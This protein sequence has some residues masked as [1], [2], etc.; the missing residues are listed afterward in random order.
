MNR[1]ALGAA[2]LLT[3]LSARAQE[4]AIDATSAARDAGAADLEPTFSDAEPAG[5]DFE[6]L[7]KIDEEIAKFGSSLTDEVVSSTKT[8]QRAAQVPA[9][10]SVVTA[11]EIQAR[12]YTSLAEVL[13]T[14]PGFYDVFDLV[15]HNIGVRGVNGGARASGNIIKLMIDGQ[16]VDYRP[17]TGNFFGEELIPLPLIDH[18]EII[19]GPASA[20]YGANAFLGV[21]NLIT[22]TGQAAAGVRVFG[23]GTLIRTNPGGGGGAMA[24]ISSEM[25]DVLVGTQAAYLNRSGLELPKSSPVL[26]QSG[27]PTATRSENDIARPKTL[28]AKATA[29]LKLVELS[30][31]ASVQNLDSGGEFLDTGP[32]THGTRVSLVNQNYRLSL[33]AQPLEA[34]TVRASAHYLSASPAGQERFDIGERGYA[35]LR[36]AGVDGFGA[37]GEVQVRAAKFLTVTIGADFVDEMYLLQTWDHLTTENLYAADGVTV[38][39]GVGTIVP[40]EAH[41]ARQTFTNVGG[42]VQGLINW[43]DDFSTVLG[44]RLDYHSLYQLNPSFRLGVVYAPA[45]RPLSLKLLYGSSFKAPSAEQLYTQPMKF[46][47]VQGNPNLTSQTAHTVELAAGFGFAS[48][49]G[50]LTVNAFGTEILNRVEYLQ[51]SF[52]LQAQNIAT[53]L[54]VG[55]E[56]DLRFAF[57]K[58][59]SAR[60]SGGVAK[61]VIETYR[62]ATIASSTTVSNALFPLAQVHLSADWAIPWQGFHL[63]AEVSYVSPRSASQSN[64]VLAAR[65]YDLRGYPYVSLV[66]STAGRKIFGHRETSAAVRVSNVLN[67]ISADSGFGGVDVPAQ[68]VTATL[69]VIQSL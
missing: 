16:P 14:V 2:V 26:S 44:A 40:G 58:A 24:G 52:F 5:D 68:G 8:A 43:N 9:V 30:F 34:V 67:T 65:A 19:R 55:G 62:F 69:T 28:F 27:A 32:L 45:S 41:G 7:V 21:V 11:E 29:R 59:I 4:E 46:L 18:V 12:G 1:F 64:A 57:T 49:R 22:K 48:G 39:R 15:T 51:R 23:Q 33:S 47:D 56:L 31:L 53:E 54:V 25:F 6:S 38:L 20:L 60:L 66:L 10:V 36:S 35:L 17:S 13:R 42:F 3:A 37:N 63:A 61:T 50:E